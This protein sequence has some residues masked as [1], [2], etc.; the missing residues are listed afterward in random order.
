MFS[1]KSHEKRKEKTKRRGRHE[2]VQTA[3]GFGT[4]EIRQAAKG[5]CVRV[6]RHGGIPDRAKIFRWQGG[7]FAE[8]R[9][10]FSLS[11][12]LGCAPEVICS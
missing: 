8:A 9:T 6:G 1:L 11:R 3:V 2:A 5:R 10:V 4:S 12:V 7:R